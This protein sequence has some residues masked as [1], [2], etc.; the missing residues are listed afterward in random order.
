MS[1]L[2]RRV[3]TF[4]DG[5]AEVWM[6]NAGKVTAAIVALGTGDEGKPTATAW[7]FVLDNG[8]TVQATEVRIAGEWQRI[9]DT[10]AQAIVDGEALDVERGA[11]SAAP[12]APARRR[13]PRSTAPASEGEG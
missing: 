2:L 7:T 11:V 3:E 9:T 4:S 8:R 5:T 1:V 10:L 13:L 12:R 6:V